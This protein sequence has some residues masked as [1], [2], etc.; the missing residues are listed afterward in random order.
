MH[1]VAKIG[2]RDLDALNAALDEWSE[3]DDGEPNYSDPCRPD[4]ILGWND[5]RAG[6]HP[7]APQDMA[8]GA[9]YNSGF[10]A[11]RETPLVN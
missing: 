1:S 10:I 7:S 4:F 8:R 11:A 5:F 3:A 2:P 6:K 9:A